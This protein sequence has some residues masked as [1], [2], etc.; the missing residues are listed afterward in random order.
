MPASVLVTFPGPGSPPTDD[1]DFAGDNVARLFS[2]AADANKSFLGQIGECALYASGS[3][4]LEQIVEYVCWGEYQDNS[5]AEAASRAGLWVGQS[6]ASLAYPKPGD[7]GGLQEGGSIGRTVFR[8]PVFDQVKGKVRSSPSSD[9]L[10]YIPQ[11]T[12]PGKKNGWPS[13]FLFQM[14]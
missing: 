5:N 14:L 13:P 12:T 3:A 9:W 2:R 7:M 1:M 6:P 10:I 4:K 8:K 11:E